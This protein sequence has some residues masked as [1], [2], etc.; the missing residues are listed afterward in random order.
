MG[1]GLHSN[2]SLQLTA[3]SGA[4]LRVPSPAFGCSG[5]N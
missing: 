2:V 4:A 3:Q 5:V 1:I